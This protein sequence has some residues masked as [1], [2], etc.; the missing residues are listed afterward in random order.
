MTSSPAPNDQPVGA[1]KALIVG[2]GSIGQRHVRNLRTLLGDRVQITAYRANRY[3]PI[4]GDRLNAQGVGTVE[5]EYQVDSFT[6]LERALAARPDVAFICNP[7]S[8]HLPVALA[9]AEAGCDLFIEKPVAA[10]LDGIETLLDLVRSKRLIAAVG[11]Q[12]RF[13]PAL[14]MLKRH[15]DEASIGPALAVRAEV[16]EY[17]PDWHPY[18]DYRRSYAARRSLGGGVILTLIHE[19]D[20]LAWLFGVPRRVFAVGGHLSGLEMDVEDVASILA[21]CS[22]A[23]RTV[24]VHLQMDYLR[25]PPRRTC[26]VLGEA[27]SLDLDLRQHSLT[28]TTIKGEQVTLFEDARLDRNTLFLAELSDFLAA[29]SERR[30]ARVTLNDGITAVRVAMA[31][32]QSIRTGNLVEIA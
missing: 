12:L 32:H 7:S 15:V 23:G 31:A 25:R 19:I 9:C 27:G 22:A 1:L 20:Y 3:S 24:P 2:L 8:L 16:G 30:Q 18:E 6:S 13:H 5:D 10:A 29:C 14:A 17:L 21:E 28:L 26:S 4:I 11:C